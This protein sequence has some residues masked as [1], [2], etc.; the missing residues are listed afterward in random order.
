LDDEEP[1]YAGCFGYLAV[2]VN[3]NPLKFLLKQKTVANFFCV[4]VYLH[5]MPTELR[6]D[7]FQAIADPNRRQIIDLLAKEPM[8]LTA[9]GSAF[10]RM[11][12]LINSQINK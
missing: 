6:R 12:T 1:D 2:I 8:T 9:I 7:I 4:S 11:E 3:D 10:D 5:I